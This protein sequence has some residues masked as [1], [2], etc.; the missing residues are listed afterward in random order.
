LVATASPPPS[1]IASSGPQRLALSPRLEALA[2]LLELGRDNSEAIG[3]PLALARPIILVIVFGRIPFGLGLD[4]RDD[5]QV[6]TL[7]VAGDCRPRF[8]FLAFVLGEYRRA[9]LRADVV[10]LR[11]S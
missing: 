4:G 8:G 7:L 11:L 3:V 10:A 2:Q 6:D 1:E 9:I 5:R